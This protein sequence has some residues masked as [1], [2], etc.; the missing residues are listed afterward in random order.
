M[1]GGCCN[2]CAVR[3]DEL[4]AV[5]AK[6]LADARAAWPDIALDAAAFVAG[7]AARLADDATIEQ[8]TALH[9][10]DLWIAAACAEGNAIAIAHFESR[11]MASLNGVLVAAKLDAYEIDEAKQEVRRK[12]LVAD[13]GPPRIADYS[14]RADL[15]TWI[16]TTAV[17]TGID[18]LRKRRP[19]MV[20]VDELAMLPA[21]GE[22]PELELVKE[23]YRDELRDAIGDATAQLSARERA[24]LKY[25]Y[26]DGASIDRIGA[27]Y[28]VHRATAARWV[29]AAREV[30]AARVHSLLSTRLG[31]SA[32]VLRSIAR[33]V[34][35]QIDLSIR[36]LLVNERDEA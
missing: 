11:Y 13:G 2:A 23:R 10:A 25:H 18:L 19:V 8:A 36:R 4:A 33:I 12:L 7:V 28:G 16:Y 30:L 1:K 24:L 17:R 29:G 21:L 32:S 14:G 9:A 34:E 27:I 31:V 26:V 5:T 22:D 15:R 3:D 20:D 6:W 35:S